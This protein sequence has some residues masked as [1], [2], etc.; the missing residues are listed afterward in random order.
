MMLLETPI[1]IRV[2]VSPEYIEWL[3]TSDPSMS[4][5]YE[6]NQEYIRTWPK[7]IN[8][9]LGKKEKIHCRVKYS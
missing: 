2:I 4:W 5:R 8:K 6:T 9:A 7:D 3:P 1:S